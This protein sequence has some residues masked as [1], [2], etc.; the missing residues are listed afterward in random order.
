M[1]DGCIHNVDTKLS[2]DLH[3]SKLRDV[4]GSVR[5]QL[6]G[7]LLSFRDDLDGVVLAYSNVKILNTTADISGFFQYFHID[8]TATLH[9]LRICKEQHLGVPRDG[10]PCHALLS[11]PASLPAST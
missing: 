8:V 1:D 4:L 3:P 6:D 11:Q 5:E 7:L 2:I 10:S 9:V